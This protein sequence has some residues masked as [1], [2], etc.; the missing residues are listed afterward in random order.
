M[1]P[2]K[3]HYSLYGTSELCAA[4]ILVQLYMIIYFRVL[5]ELPSNWPLQKYIVQEKKEKKE[6]RISIYFALLLSSFIP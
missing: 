6:G 1:H 2:V 3:I 5:Q 4:I